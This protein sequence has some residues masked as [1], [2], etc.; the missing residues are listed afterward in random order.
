MIAEFDLYDLHTTLALLAEGAGTG[1]GGLDSAPS[2][3][4]PLGLGDPMCRA[5]P[6]LYP[7]TFICARLSSRCNGSDSPKLTTTNGN[8][9]G[10]AA[11][12]AAV[13]AVGAVG[14]ASFVLVI[15]AEQTSKRISIHSNGPNNTSTSMPQ[16]FKLLVVWGGERWWVGEEI[17]VFG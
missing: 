11:A 14:A 16:P 13:G 1:A 15:V 3:S 6:L 7:L 8:A 5:Y 12:G 10:A 9:G 2:S 4:Y 17:T